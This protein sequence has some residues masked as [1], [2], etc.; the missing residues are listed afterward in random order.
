LFQEMA[1][2]GAP[3]GQFAING[4]DDIAAAVRHFFAAEAQAAEAAHV[5]AAG[6]A[7]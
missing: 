2:G 6:T 7:P 3:S 5:G 4:P 1:G